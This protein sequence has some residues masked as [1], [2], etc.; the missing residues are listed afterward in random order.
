MNR[1]CCG[2]GRVLSPPMS[3][4]PPDTI[5]ALR[6]LLLFLVILGILV[7]TID[8][9]L[10]KHYEDRF[11]LPPLALNTIA[12]IT[13]VWFMAGESR[14][15]LRAIQLLMVVFVL[16]GLAGVYLHFQ[17]NLEFQLEIDPSQSRWE[18]FKKVMRATAPPALAPPVLAYLGLLGLVFSYRHPALNSRPDADEPGRG[19]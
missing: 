18:L 9:L 11:Q 8:L 4:L 12:G 1:D 7:T 2:A 15:S 5:T 10:L 17:G 16:A 3:M 19:N 6:R 14:A 13:F